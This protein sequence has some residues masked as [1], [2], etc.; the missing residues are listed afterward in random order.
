MAHTH[1]S[2]Q[3]CL[4]ASLML[5]TGTTIHPLLTLVVTMKLPIFCFFLGIYTFAIQI[6]MP[7]ILWPISVSE[8]MVG[9]ARAV[10]Q[11]C[12][13]TC[14]VTQRDRAHLPYLCPGHGLSTT[15]G[16][17]TAELR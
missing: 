17:G 16:A 8:G 11:V 13:G 7:F 2:Q 4:V 3:G 9:S 5:F 10:V 6:Y 1:I 14:K 15:G 12:L